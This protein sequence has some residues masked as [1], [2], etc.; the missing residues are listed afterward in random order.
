LDT[1]SPASPAAFDSVAN[2][3]GFFF[4]AVSRWL[5]LVAGSHVLDFHSVLTE[6]VCPVGQAGLQPADL[7]KRRAD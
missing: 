5:I 4:R 2:S 6:R 1:F 7:D 3:P